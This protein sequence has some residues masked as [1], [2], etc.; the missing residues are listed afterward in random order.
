MPYKPDL[1]PTNSLQFNFFEKKKKLNEDLS[2]LRLPVGFFF[3]LIL[4]TMNLP[5][6]KKSRL[7]IRLIKEPNNSFRLLKIF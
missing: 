3:F 5:L 1:K 6:E 2:N 4:K 7:T